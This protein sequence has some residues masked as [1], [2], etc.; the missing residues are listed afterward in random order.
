MLNLEG[1]KRS[2]KDQFDD[3]GDSPWLEGWICGYTDREHG[4]EDSTEVYDALFEYL[5]ELRK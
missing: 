2:I 1:A 3:F 5:D 4:Y